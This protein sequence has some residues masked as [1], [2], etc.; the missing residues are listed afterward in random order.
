MGAQL[1]PGIAPAPRGRGASRRSVPASPTL[2]YG[3]HGEPTCAGTVPRRDMP[4]RLAARKEPCPVDET[5]PSHTG[6]PGA[7][8]S[9]PRTAPQQ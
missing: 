5:L 2:R 9:S 1:L 4:G 8:R 7:G 6:H 3:P